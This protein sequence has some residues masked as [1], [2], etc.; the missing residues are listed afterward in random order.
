MAPPADETQPQL[1]H[2]RG[3]QADMLAQIITSPA[4][5][6]PIVGHDSAILIPGAGIAGDRYATGRG[7]YSGVKEWDGHVTLIR[8]EPFEALAAQGVAI[9]P[10]DLRRNLV[11]RGIDLASLIG[12]RFRVGNEA[13]LR[14]RKA[15]PPCVHIV[16]QSGRTEIF[17][18]LS[19]DS[20][21]GADVLVGGKIR[22]G[23]PIVLHDEP[24][25][26]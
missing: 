10:R 17:K 13:I 9:D 21:I 18:F 6:Q 26:S 23:D 7:F 1:D 19:K 22:V 15:W 16:K 8:L 3:I 2:R 25:A 20:G 24:A 5:G 14:G 4:S 12:R 11:T